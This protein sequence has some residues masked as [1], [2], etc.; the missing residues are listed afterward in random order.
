ML[1]LWI[2]IL[3]RRISVYCGGNRA[4]H[5]DAAFGLDWCWL[6]TV[7]HRH[8]MKLENNRYESS[9]E[10]IQTQREMKMTRAVSWLAGR[11]KKQ[12]RQRL[13]VKEEHL[14]KWVNGVGLRE[15]QR[16]KK[17]RR[18]IGRSEEIFR[19][20]RVF[21]QWKSAILILNE[22]ER[23]QTE[24]EC[25][26]AADVLVFRNLIHQHR[27]RRHLN[28]RLNLAW[29]SNA[30]RHILVVCEHTKCSLW[31]LISSI[32]NE[33]ECVLSEQEQKS[34]SDGEVE[35]VPVL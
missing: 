18:E 35:W 8:T 32:E 34:L 2:K 11:G 1:L 23:N 6:S 15:K 9:T 19:W 24:R 21:N 25:C 10:N 22:E 4:R 17:K 27:R 7:T 33:N 13:T 26:D 5:D 12:Q 20:K 16:K 14:L 31:R 3:R 29:N 28:Q 30:T